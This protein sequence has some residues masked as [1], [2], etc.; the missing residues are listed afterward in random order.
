[1]KSPNNRFNLTQGI[2]MVPAKVLAQE[3]MNEMYFQL[4]II[5]VQHTLA[6]DLTFGFEL[7]MVFASVKYRVE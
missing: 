5:C 3:Q 6:A 7:S 1:M 4:K 2:V